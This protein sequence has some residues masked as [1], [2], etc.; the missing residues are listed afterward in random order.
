LW[1][2]TDSAD[3]T[4]WTVF[5]RMLI[6]SGAGKG[7]VVGSPSLPNRTKL[8][9]AAYHESADIMTGVEIIWFIQVPRAWSEESVAI[10]L[11][12]PSIAHLAPTGTHAQ[13]PPLPE[14]AFRDCKQG[15]YFFG[16]QELLPGNHVR[17]LNPPSETRPPR[18]HFRRKM[19]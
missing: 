11:Y 6:A 8:L 2:R 16:G 4:D 15:R 7:V 14:S 10:C 3:L 5:F 1:E 17:H 19:R 18:F 13:A 9:R 12:F